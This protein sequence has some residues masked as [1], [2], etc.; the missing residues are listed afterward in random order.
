MTRQAVA[1]VSWFELAWLEPTEVNANHY[2]LV[3][4]GLVS[5]A[6]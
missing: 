1:A 2:A 4:A 6:R 3:S 5:L